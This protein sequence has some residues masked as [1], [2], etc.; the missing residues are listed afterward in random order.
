MI[1]HDLADLVSACHRSGHRYQEFIQ[2]P[3]MSAGIFILPAGALDD[4]EPHDRDE[5]Y[6][7]IS[8][9]GTLRVEAEDREVAAGSLMF[10]PAGTEHHFHSITEQLVMLVLFGAGS[11]LP[12]VQ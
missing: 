2:L 10:V 4:H 1:T 6:H 3:T 12:G 7:V 8:G 5:L 11:D 9:R